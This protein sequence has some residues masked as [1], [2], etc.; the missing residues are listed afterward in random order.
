MVCKCYKLSPSLEL[1][2]VRRYFGL[3]KADAWRR[4]AVLSGDAL[5]RIL[6][7]DPGQ[8]RIHFF[9]FGCLCFTDLN[10][11]EITR[12]LR[13]AAPLFPFGSPAATS[14]EV[15]TD[16]MINIP[17][18][19]EGCLRDVVPVMLARSV[20]LSCLNTDINVLLDDSE[21][22]IDRLSHNRRWLHRR[23]MARLNIRLLRFQYEYVRRLGALENNDGFA[24]LGQMKARTAVSDVLEL[25]GRLSAFD[26]KLTELSHMI[27]FYRTDRF[28]STMIGCSWIEVVML[29]AFPF[30]DV[31]PHGM[32]LQTVMETVRSLVGQLLNG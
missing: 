15:L 30:L 17:S 14:A 10:D 12:F 13:Q 23:M 16:K 26:G 7:Y 8:S 3:E 5:A 2:T 29:T 21:Q 11:D 28:S 4:C 27:H 1:Q 6:E 20:E 25:T 24:M 18:L 19:D 31:M 22:L 9:D 32:N